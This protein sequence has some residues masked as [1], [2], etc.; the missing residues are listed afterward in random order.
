M[1]DKM[2]QAIFL[3]ELATALTR[4]ATKLMEEWG[5]ETFGI[6]DLEARLAECDCGPDSPCHG[7]YAPNGHS[8]CCEHGLDD[9]PERVLADD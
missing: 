2:Q 1:T 5:D 6:V 9:C 8:L 4:D 3:M 7:A